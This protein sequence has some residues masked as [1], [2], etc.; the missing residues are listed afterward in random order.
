M[1]RLLIVFA[2]IMMGVTVNAQKKKCCHIGLGFKAG[3]NLAKYVGKDVSTNTVL[4]PYAGAS[5]N[6]K[7]SDKFLIKQEVL[8]SS[9]GS[10]SGTDATKE[11]FTTSYLALPLM[12]QLN[13]SKSIFLETGPQLNFLIK[14]DYHAGDQTTD[15]KDSYQPATLGWDLGIGAKLKSGFGVNARYAPAFGNIFKDQPISAHSS[16][17]AIGFFYNLWTK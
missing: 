7:F 2:A 5:V 4:K 10:Q 14:A 8:F 3:T 17:I 16:V 11:R 13:I 9:E 15:V 6:F 12:L 1:K